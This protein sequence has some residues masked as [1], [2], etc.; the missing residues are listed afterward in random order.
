VG[1]SFGATPAG[2]RVDLLLLPRL[3]GKRKTWPS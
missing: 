1:N 3:I 2:G